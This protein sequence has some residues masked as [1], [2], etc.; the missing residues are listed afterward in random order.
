[1]YDHGNGN[2]ERETAGLSCRGLQA[3]GEASV[4]SFFRRKGH[5]LSSSED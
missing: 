3:L 5:R 2:D 1:L 4:Y